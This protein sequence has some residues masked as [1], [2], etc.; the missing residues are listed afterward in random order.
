MSSCSHIFCLE[1]IR[2]WRKKQL[3]GNEVDRAGHVRPS[4]VTKSCP[5]CRTPSLYVV[6]SSYFPANAQQKETIIRKYKE[7]TSKVPCKH[8]QESGAR[9]WCPFED[10][11]FFAHLDEN[12]RPC[13][14]N[15]NSNPRRQREVLRSYVESDQYPN[16]A[17]RHRHHPQ[18]QPQSRHHGE[19]YNLSRAWRSLD[20]NILVNHLL[21]EG[22]RS[23]PPSGSVTLEQF[24]GYL[25][26]FRPSLSDNDWG[27]YSDDY[28]DEDDIDDDDDV[29]DDDVDDDDY[30]DD[31]DD[32]Y[33]DD[34][35]LSEYD[36]DYD[37][38][39]LE[40]WLPR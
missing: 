30:E 11:C 22:F 39:Y 31:D 29:D 19:D 21:D 10:A 15:K 12:G 16:R 38:D 26:S 1:C 8:F 20:P 9:R 13:S 24:L 18:P 37:S 14:V 27:G 34:D 35:G 40:M 36:S 23:S 3:P 33:F 7:V 32:D 28:D 2:T 17:S 4:S 25:T 6:P 5:S